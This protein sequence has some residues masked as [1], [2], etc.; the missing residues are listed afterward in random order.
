MVPEISL[1]GLKSTVV[2]VLRHDSSVCFHEPIHAT[3]PS[4]QGLRYVPFV[5][6]AGCDYA[7]ERGGSPYTGWQLCAIEWFALSALH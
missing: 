6:Q 5:A 7:V 4:V 2:R 3:T 1:N